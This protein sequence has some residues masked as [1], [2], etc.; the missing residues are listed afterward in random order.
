VLLPSLL[1][2][3]DIRSVAWQLVRLCRSVPVSMQLPVGMWWLMFL[4]SVY[5]ILMLRLCLHG[6]IVTI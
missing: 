5:T 2:I 6:Q 4:L 3:A 1:D